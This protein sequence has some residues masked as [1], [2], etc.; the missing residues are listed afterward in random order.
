MKKLILGAGLIL[1]MP[2]TVSGD[3]PTVAAN[4]ALSRVLVDPKTKVVFYLESDQ[5]HIAAI[6]PEGRLLWCKTVTQKT[7]KLW[8]IVRFKLLKSGDLNVELAGSGSGEAILDS[9]TGEIVIIN[10]L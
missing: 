1:V 2:M 7:Y 5:Q 3:S 6:S 4:I 9:Q 8:R 10:V